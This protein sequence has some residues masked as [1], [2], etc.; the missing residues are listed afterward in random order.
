MFY[1]EYEKEVK[2]S[3]NNSTTRGGEW[4]VWLPSL[5]CHVVQLEWQSYQVYALLHFILKKFR[6]IHFA[7]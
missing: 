2:L 3:H 6:G 5:L 1:E 4:N 7:L